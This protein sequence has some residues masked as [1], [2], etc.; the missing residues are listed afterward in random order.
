[1]SPPP[2]DRADMARTHDD[3]WDLA[4]SVGATATMIAAGRALATKD[5]RGLIN[6]PFAEQLV[7]AVGLEFFVKMIDGSLDLS[8]IEDASPQRR[9][10]M[11]NNIAVR[12]KYFDSALMAAVDA[13]ARQVVILAS[14]LDSRAYRLR[15]PAGT[16]VYE[17]DQPQV[18]EF[19]TTTL[20]D[21]G[22]EPTAERRT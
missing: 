12:T 5:P 20:A 8:A 3:S 1:M 15:W 18:I 2:S 9:E 4:S 22:A 17:V 10:A 11:I 13:G 7:R 19:K 6:D 16:V 14:G 21:F